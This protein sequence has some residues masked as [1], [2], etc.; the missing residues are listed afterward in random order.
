[1]HP[2]VYLKN[3]WLSWTVLVHKSMIPNHEWTLISKKKVKYYTE[4]AFIFNFSSTS[5]G[6]AGL[7]GGDCF[8]AR[9]GLQLAAND[10][11]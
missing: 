8:A 6:G 9:F 7:H 4:C 10:C 11:L 3:A 2:V 5:S 1:M